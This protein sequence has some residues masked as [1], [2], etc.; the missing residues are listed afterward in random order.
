MPSCAEM[1][2]RTVNRRGISRDRGNGFGKLYIKYI[3]L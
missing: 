2:E 1:D 3:L